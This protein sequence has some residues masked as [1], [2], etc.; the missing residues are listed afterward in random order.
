[1]AVREGQRLYHFPPPPMYRF[2]GRAIELLE[3]ERAFRRHPAVV[4]TGMGG[5]GKTALAR[6][7]AAWWLRAGRFDA[8]VF[9]TFEFKAGAERVVQLLGQ[10]L[11]GDNFSARSSE[12]QWKTAVDLFHRQRVLLV[13]DN[14]ESVLPAFQTPGVSETPGVLAQL[15]QLYRDLTQ[16][17]HGLPAGR[18]LLTCRPAETGL[19][20]IKEIPLSGLKRP[21][22]LYLL[23]R[24][25]R[26]QGHLDRP[27]RLRARS[28]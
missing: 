19:P 9:C 3:L 15:I 5:M 13:W 24:R 27:C 7:A 4:L 11:E 21:D 8:A 2:H 28:D 14:F 10:A 22:S 16:P 12:D 18:L 25:A 1:M 23:C 6:E 20:G 17:E 26:P